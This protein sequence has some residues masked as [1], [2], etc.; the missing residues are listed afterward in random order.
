MMSAT[1]TLSAAVTITRLMLRKLFAHDASVADPTT[2]S[3]LPFRSAIASA[4]ALVDGVSY[5]AGSQTAS[6]PRSACTDSAAR[7]AFL[8]ALRLTLTVYERGD[9]P[10]ATPP[11]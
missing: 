4:A 2:T 7:S 11:P 6:E 5:A 10:N 3:T 8:R 1:P 9:G